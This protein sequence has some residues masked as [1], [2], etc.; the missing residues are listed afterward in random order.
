MTG[1]DTASFTLIES[2]VDYKTGI[3]AAV[4]VAAA[5]AS[6]VKP[7][8][9]LSGV[10]AES[11]S[12]NTLAVASTVMGSISYVTASMPAAEREKLSWSLDEMLDWCTYEEQEC[13]IA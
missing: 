3:F 12:N 9:A 6:L 1:P 4:S 5:A 7:N 2:F 11:K 13:D 10:V 8:G